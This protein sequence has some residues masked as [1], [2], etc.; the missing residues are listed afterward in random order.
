MCRHVDDPG[1]RKP[2]LFENDHYGLYKLAD[3]EEKVRL[4]VKQSQEAVAACAEFA[5]LLA[6]V[7]V[8]PGGNAPSETVL[9][10]SEPTKPR[11]GRPP[12][13]TPVEAGDAV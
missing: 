1:G 10:S 11:R 3:S 4:A 7:H 2:T 13:Q 6:D 5:R 12:K 9:P 8:P